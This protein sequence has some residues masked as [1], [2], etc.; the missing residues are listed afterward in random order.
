M[1]KTQQKE[2]HNQFKEEIDRV[3]HNNQELSEKLDIAREMVEKL[4]TTRQKY[5]AV[6]NEK[7]TLLRARK[8]LGQQVSQWHS[9]L[10]SE[11]ETTTTVGY[12]IATKLT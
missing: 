8:A 11:R 4:K 2:R 1:M 7:G 6:I 10:S 3:F 5:N 12:N 9:V